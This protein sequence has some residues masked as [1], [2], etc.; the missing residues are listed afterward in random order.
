MVALAGCEDLDRSVVG[1]SSSVAP[2]SLASTSPTGEF[3]VEKYRYTTRGK[4][5]PAQNHGDFYLPTGTHAVDTVPLVVLIHGGSWQSHIGFD[6]M[7][8]YAADLAR[9][10]M[11]VYNIEYRPDLGQFSAQV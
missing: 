4:S 7:S 1:E 9:R 8:F 6:T 11:A 10:G 5:D 2:S 3:T